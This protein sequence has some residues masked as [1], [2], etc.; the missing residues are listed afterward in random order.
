[1]NVLISFRKKTHGYVYHELALE[2]WWQLINKNNINKRI[3]K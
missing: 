3:E 1:M 2:I